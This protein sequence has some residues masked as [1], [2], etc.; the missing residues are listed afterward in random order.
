VD[1]ESIALRTGGTREEVRAALGRLSRASLVE[2]A[3]SPRLT[4][5]GLAVAVASGA[6][7]VRRR[8]V[9]VP[10]RRAA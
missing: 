10:A 7:V 8:A 3:A 2:R 9:R 6:A 5:A 4:M 1:C